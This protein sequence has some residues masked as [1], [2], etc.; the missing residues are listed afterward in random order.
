MEF[1]A[2]YT[3]LP[4]A[5]KLAELFAESFPKLFYRIQNWQKVLDLEPENSNITALPLICYDFMK[6]LSRFLLI[7]NV[8]N[9]ERCCIVHG[10]AA[11]GML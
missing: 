9:Q 2:S 5:I 11:S 8:E 10:P 4:C 7:C 6:I 3:S 1:A